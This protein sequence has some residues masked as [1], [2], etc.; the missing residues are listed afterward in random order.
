METRRTP[1]RGA[2]WHTARHVVPVAVGW[3]AAGAALVATALLSSVLLPASLVLLAAGSALAIAG[4]ATATALL[5]S[6]SR[7]GRDGTVGWDF[8]SAL[9]FLGFAAALLA[10][11]GEA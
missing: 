2:A 9:V 4:F 3:T 10:D 1:A 5:L 6:G 7:M 8:A 11:T